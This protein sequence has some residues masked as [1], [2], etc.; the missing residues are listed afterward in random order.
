[1]KFPFPIDSHPLFEILYFISASS[2]AVMALEMG[3]L[4]TLFVGLVIYVRAHFTD[5]LLM[6]ERDG[7]EQ[8]NPDAQEESIRRCIEYHK[9][10][11]SLVDRV[12]GAMSATIFAQYMAGTFL[13]CTI[14]FQTREGENIPV[15]VSF[16]FGCTT[17]LFMYSYYG[18]HLKEESVRVAERIYSDLNWYER[19][20]RI[21]KLLLFFLLRAQRPAKLT[22]LNFFDCS[23]DT[24]MMVSG[25]YN[26]RRFIYNGSPF[27]IYK[28]SLSA[29]ALLQTLAKT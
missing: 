21:R 16:L 27:Q 9:Q 20:P 1:M 13:L 12:Q 8:E 15:Y 5:L 24:F 6:I 17:Q 14:I 28:T 11:L 10:V 7:Q 3:M 23:L 2:V 4:D 22:A 25:E 26:L 19:P 29:V 18:S